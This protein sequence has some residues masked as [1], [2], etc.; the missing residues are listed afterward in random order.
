MASWDDSAL[1]PSKYLS[2]IKAAKVRQHRKQSCVRSR[3]LRIEGLERR[4]LLAG[5][6]L[7]THGFGGNTDGWISTMADAIVARTEHSVQP[8]Y[9]IEVTDPGDLG[10]PLTV[11]RTSRSGPSVTELADPELMILLDWSDVAGSFFSSR[12]R[13]TFDVA[14]AVA[15]ALTDPN[16][17]DDL[18]GSLSQLPLHL[19]GHSRGGSL[20]GELAHQLGELGVWVDHVTTL[21]PHPVDGIR[22]PFG[23]DYGDAPMIARENVVFWDNYWRTDGDNSL[24]FTGEAIDNTYNIQ[25]DES[26]LNASEGY[27]NEH[28]DVHLWYHGTIDTEGTFDDGSESVGADAGWFD[29]AMGPRDEIGYYFSKTI[30][31]VRPNEGVAV[32]LGGTAARAA[33]TDHSDDKWPS[34]VELQVT[35]ST[36]LQV[37]SELSTSFYWHDHDGD[38]SVTY[39]LDSDRNPLNGTGPILGD[40]ITLALNTPVLSERTYTVTTNGVE[41]GDYYLLASITSDAKTRFAYA[42][43]LLTLIPR[44]SITL[45]ANTVQGNVRGATVGTLRVAGIGDSFTLAVDDSRFTIVGDVLRLRDNASLPGDEASN[46]SL[47]ITATQAGS[48]STVL[49]QQVSVTVTA[50]PF[51]WSNPSNPL[52]ANNDGSVAPI[53]ALVII[54]FIDSGASSRLP[55]ARATTEDF[56]FDTNRDGFVAPIDVLV[57]INFID[58]QLQ[59]EGESGARSV[60]QRATKI[61]RPTVDALV[62]PDAVASNFGR[63]AE[64]HITDLSRQRRPGDADRVLRIDDFFEFLADWDESALW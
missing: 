42:D 16:L 26:V 52:D 29:G 22:D 9:V 63:V 13:N 56:F 7:I 3:R 41:V 50:N 51:A 62:I 10:G 35:A 33:I 49:Q 14:E 40:A 53:D 27:F 54:N 2:D 59:P 64:L 39:Y 38:A 46:I 48:S 60:I 31:G 43:S 28:S 21:D 57:V 1:S 45:D 8:R 30:G 55:Q 34:L 19:I 18:Q 25:L 24:D 20:V 4:D 6:T 47:K 11:Q 61:Q 5:V 44:Q 15:A 32:A 17:L 12:I 23:Q 58:D 37:G 36:T